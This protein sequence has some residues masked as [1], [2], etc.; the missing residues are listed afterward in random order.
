[1][2]KNLPDGMG[3]AV[4]RPMWRL[5]RL[6]PTKYMADTLLV[7]RER[8]PLW[9]PVALGSGIALYFSLSVE[10]PFWLGWAAVVCCMAA[11][12]WGC[13]RAVILL[14]AIFAATLS[15][16]FS[17]AQLRTMIAAAPVL[18]KSAGVIRV[19]GEVFDVEPLPRGQ[20]VTLDHVTLDRDGPA[21]RR[22]RLRLTGKGQELRPGQ[23]VALRAVL[24]PPPQPAAPG[25]FDFARQ[26]WFDGLGAVGYGVGRVDLL[27]RGEEEGAG[28][29][30]G[31]WLAALRHDMT[32]RIVA[33]IGDG[34]G[35]VA[36]ALMSGQ[37]TAID[38]TV[39]ENYRISG[40]AHLLSISGLHMSLTAGLVFFAMRGALALIPPVA[41]RY[42]IKKWT[43]AVALLATFAY[44][45]IAGSPVPAQRSF[46]MTAIV[47]LAI[48]VDR[49]ALSM[50]TI[51][52]AAVA[53]LLWQPDALIGAS[54]QMSFAAVL[55]L[56]AAYEGMGRRIM[57]WRREGGWMRAGL[58]YVGGVAFTTLIAGTATSFYGLYHFNRFAT[59]SL[60]ANLM[61]VPLTSF[62]IMPWAVVAFL[63]MPFGLEQ[64]ALTPLGWGVALCNDIAAWVA[65]WPGATL[66]V[67]AMPV[68]GL[69]IFTFGGLWLCLWREKWRWWGLA[70]M[71]LALACIPLSPPPD[72]LVSSDAA[73]MAVRGPDGALILSTPQRR[74][75]ALQ[76]WMRRDG[77]DDLKPALFFD[78]AAEMPGSPLSCDAQGCLYRHGARV[79]ALVRDPS[80][81][82]EDCRN[83]DAVIAPMPVR[84]ACASVTIDR[85]SVWREGAHALWL[86][87]GGIRVQSVADWQGDRPWSGR[88]G[89]KDESDGR[90]R[91][92]DE[93]E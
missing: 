82:A 58:V 25:A 85:F 65:S 43:A 64:W 76:S 92:E 40:L 24:T 60:A 54:F 62:W 15:L 26:A 29:R 2:G 13:R 6:N 30:L 3:G 38:T 18:E 53:V 16:G 49:T 45:L 77:D 57:A 59:W 28:R 55:A 70:P 61:A 91:E 69:L 75:L 19:K 83:A 86:E 74:S 23:R 52:W 32:L 31:L 39:I 88:R 80:A 93:E 51:A 5:A 14:P 35:G 63:L 46:L 33:G 66:S 79:V 36:A 56:I 87:P 73:L 10:P 41:L 34:A 9:L 7:E 48:M 12:L 21:P 71:A 37:Q 42:P 4:F 90:E 1:M 50:R 47:L 67:P 44:M 20:R 27:D 89:R 84:R 17:A 22:I 72:V 8:W 68:G 78:Q 81:L 11:S